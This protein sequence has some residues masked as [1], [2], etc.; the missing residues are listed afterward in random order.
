MPS[1]LITEFMDQPAVDLLESQLDVQYDPDLFGHPDKLLNDVG[2]HDALIVRNRTQ[3]T[4]DLIARA[5]ALKIVGRLGVGLDNIDLQ[6]CQDR[7]VQVAPATGANSVSVAEYV[8]GAIFS[9]HR[10]ITAAFDAVAQ[11]LWPRTQMIGRELAGQTLG[12]VGMGEIATEVAKRANAFGMQIVYFDPYV[13][14]ASI[15]R[16]VPCQPMANLEAML[17]CADCVSLHVPLNDATRNLINADRLQTMKPGALLINTAR[18]GVVDEPAL[19]D[20]LVSGHLGGAAM[21]VFV[22]EPMG[23]A[24]GQL[25]AGVQ[26]LI[27]TPHIA[28]V[29]VESNARVSHVTAINVLRALG[30]E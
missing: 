30:Y 9:L 21:D 28:G 14:P 6:A 24:R 7:G 10:P 11:G 5:P 19:V 16:Q 3:V 23:Q 2:S 8:M 1:V 22:D 20:A 4:A 26:R 15:A 29:T 27:L 18:G 12:L 17:A 25:F 13:S